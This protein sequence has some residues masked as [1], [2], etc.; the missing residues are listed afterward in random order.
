MMKNISLH[1]DSFCPVP[2]CTLFPDERMDKNLIASFLWTVT[3]PLQSKN[4]IRFWTKWEKNYLIGIKLTQPSCFINS[5]LR[6]PS[7]LKGQRLLLFK[8]A[9]SSGFLQ[10]SG[11]ETVNYRRAEGGRGR[12]RA[13]SGRYRWN[14]WGGPRAQELIR[15][16]HLT[17]IARL[18]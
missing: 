11:F 10:W 17:E 1:W 12:R 3:K 2:F 13:Q 6:K 15:I 18:A 14:Y 5:L 16:P 9:L 8:H 4:V 7:K